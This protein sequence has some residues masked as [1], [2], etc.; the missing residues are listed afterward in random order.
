MS[1]IKEVKAMSY[2]AKRVRN[3]ILAASS[4]AAILFV[5]PALASGTPD[6]NS[7]VKKLVVD[8]NKG[9]VNAVAA[10][11]A[12]RTSIVDGFPPYAWQTC[13]DWMKGY[14]ANNE[15]IHAALGTLSFGKPLYTDLQKNYAYVVYPV[16]FTDAPN[17]KKVSY[18]GTM[19]VTLE[20]TQRGW[21]FTGVASAWTV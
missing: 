11:C 15:A 3:L 5:G 21:V 1:Y 10:A 16:T 2:W 18:K 19:T 14:E 8:I 7:I 20:K 13:A 4:G 12:P 17:G 6:V 9:D